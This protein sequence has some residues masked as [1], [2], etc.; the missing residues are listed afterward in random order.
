MKSRK[1]WRCGRSSLLYLAHQ[2]LTSLVRI[3]L[4]SQMYA[5]S[6]SMC[7]VC[8]CMLRLCGAPVSSRKS[9]H[10]SVSFIVSTILMLPFHPCLTLEIEILMPKFR[11]HYCLSF[12]ATCLAPPCIPLFTIRIIIIIIIIIINIVT[13]FLHSEQINKVRIVYYLPSKIR[14]IEL[15][16]TRLAGHG[17]RVG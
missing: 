7:C 14:V 17:A 13:I 2:P 8:T 11:L 1:L 10:L 6:F 5:P 15:I 9:Y 3:L 16:K 4:G 12:L